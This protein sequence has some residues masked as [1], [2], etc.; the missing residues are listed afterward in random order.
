[1]PE[2]TYEESSSAILIR[3]GGIAGMVITTNLKRVSF[4]KRYNGGII[5]LGSFVKDARVP[6]KRPNDLKF[7]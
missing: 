4:T 3:V 6:T 1:M 7:L 5:Y 2:F